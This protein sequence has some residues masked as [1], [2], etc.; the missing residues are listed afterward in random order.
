MRR[1]SAL[2]RLLAALAGLALVLPSALPHPAAAA[3]G[4]PAAALALICSVD[5]AEAPG[6]PG[7]GA[8]HDPC[9]GCPGAC[10]GM[11]GALASAGLPPGFVSWP[12]AHGCAAV[13]AAT[14]PVATDAHAPRAPPAA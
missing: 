3:P 8:R 11:A 10:H 13:P 7:T 5:G 4:G 6:T 9:D 12:P 14:A 2:R 1:P